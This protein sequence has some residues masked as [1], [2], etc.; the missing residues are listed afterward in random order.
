M[1]RARLC[2]VMLLAANLAFA[3]SAA[4]PSIRNLSHPAPHRMAS[5]ALD[6][7]D[8]PTLRQAGV[9]EIIS[10]RTPEETPGFDEAKVVRSAGMTYRNL[11]IHGAKGLTRANVERFDALLRQA[12]DKITLV[13][14]AS[15]NRVGA[16]I[17]LRAAWLQHKSPAEALAEG[18][19]WGLKSLASAVRA[20]LNAPT[21]TEN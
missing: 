12:G 20:R 5:G 2:S 21:T 4:S 8:M 19:R 16:M 17:A 11:P 6:A 9:K 3:G 7:A 13:H 15:S 1:W 14:C 18:Q 10:L